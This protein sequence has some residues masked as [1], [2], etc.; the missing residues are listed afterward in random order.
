MLYPD[1]SLR[2]LVSMVTPLQ[3][4]LETWSAAVRGCGLIF[5]PARVCLFSFIPLSSS[6]I[7]TIY[8]ILDSYVC[9]TLAQN[10]F[11]FILIVANTCSGPLI[12]PHAMNLSLSENANTT[13]GVDFTLICEDGY[14]ASPNN[15]TLLCDESGVWLN[16]A[17][18]EGKACIKF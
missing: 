5:Q 1:R 9:L 10:D 7:L 14:S 15:G 2:S 11:L 6:S 4:L 17:S 13:T 16:P 18:C 8:C 3:K 12:I